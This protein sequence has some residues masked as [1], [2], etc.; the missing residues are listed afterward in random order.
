MQAHASAQSRVDAS[1]AKRVY[2]HSVIPGG[3]RG[4]AELA[5]V[6]ERDAVVRAHYADFDS[7]NARVVHVERA[8]LVHVSYRMGDDIYWTKK[9]VRLVK[10]EALLTDGKSF[11]RARCGNRIADIAQLA[12]SR[13]EPAPEELDTVISPQTANNSLQGNSP[14]SV[15]LRSAANQGLS[16]H[17]RMGAAPRA[18]GAMTTAQPSAPGTGPRARQTPAV[19][20]PVP[21]VAQLAKGTIDQ[22]TALVPALAGAGDNDVLKV[23]LTTPATA[24]TPPGGAV[25]IGGMLPSQL[26]PAASLTTPSSQEIVDATQPIVPTMVDLESPLVEVVAIDTASEVPEPGAISLF[27]LALGLIGLMRSRAYTAQ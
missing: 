6:L 23:L 16:N 7:A 1:P 9:T 19:A 24:V 21:T 13:N 12:V 8:R 2:G 22:I 15:A 11:V 27:L 18:T 10:G 4:S 3:V 17:A 25:P 26:V 14:V 5:S 20:A